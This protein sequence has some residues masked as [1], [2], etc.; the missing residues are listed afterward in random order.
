MWRYFD[1]L[2]VNDR[3]NIVTAGEGLVPIDRWEFLEEYARRRFQIRCQVFAHRQ[4]DN[5][6][7]GTFKDLSG[8]IVSSVLKENGI[9]NFVASSTGNTAVAYARYLTAAG[10]SFYAFIPKNASLTQAAEIGCFGQNV[11]RVKGDYTLTK[12]IAMAFARKHKMP[13]ILR[14]TRMRR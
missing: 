7:T 4:D 2:P 14:T 5:Y 13:L 1:V 3:K 8:S 6:A 12:E 9:Q 11:F 10:I